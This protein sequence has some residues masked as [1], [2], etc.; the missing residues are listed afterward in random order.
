MQKNITTKIVAILLATLM[1]IGILPLDINAAG[2][3]NACPVE[4]PTNNYRPAEQYVPATKTI[5][6][7]GFRTLSTVRDEFKHEEI[8][9]DNDEPTTMSMP[10]I[11]QENGGYST[12]SVEAADWDIDNQADG[13]FWPLAQ[14]NNLRR[15][16]SIS[17]PYRAPDI[18]YVG[19]YKNADGDDVIRLQFRKYNGSQSR[20]WR[21]LILKFDKNIYEAI[22]WDNPKTCMYHGTGSSSGLWNVS[23]DNYTGETAKFIPVIKSYSGGSYTVE[24]DIFN[25]SNFATFMTTFTP[26]DFVLKKGE[27]AKL[28]N[29]EYLIQAR[30]MDSLYKDVY[31]NTSDAADVTTYSAYTMS[32]VLPFKG[33]YEIESNPDLSLTIGDT[34][35]AN[36]SPVKSAS[37]YVVYDEVN[38]YV[39]VFHKQVK[40]SLSDHIGLGS[41]NAALGFRQAVNKEFYDLLEPNKDGVVAIMTIADK[42]D[43]LYKS[44]SDNKQSPILNPKKTITFKKQA[45]ATDNQINIVGDVGFIQAAGS[46]WNVNQDFKDGIKTAI[47]NNNMNNIIING[48]DTMGNSGASTMVRYFVNKDKLNNLIKQ[49][50][51]KSYA[52]YSAV[53]RQDPIGT[54]VFKQKT[55]NKD[56][57]L[58]KG[59]EVIFDFNYNAN[60]GW[61]REFIIGTKPYSINFINSITKVDNN[62]FKW[63]IP[64]DITIPANTDITYKTV[65]N[66]SAKNPKMTVVGLGLTPIDMD[67]PVLENAPRVLRGS[68]TLAGGALVSTNYVVSVDE[69][70]TE[71]KKITG[72]SFYEVAEITISS[73]NA[74]EDKMDE[75]KISASNTKG[76]VTLK[77][78]DKKTGKKIEKNFESYKFDTGIPNPAGKAQINQYKEFVMPNLKKDMPIIVSNKDV[79]K[80][81]TDSRDVVEQVQAR[82]YFHYNNATRDEDE[83]VDARVMPLNSEFLY[84]TSGT[85]NPA[86]IPNGFLGYK[87]DSDEVVDNRRK[88][89][90]D[91]LSDHNG[92]PLEGEELKKRQMP[93][94]KG[95]DA[96]VKKEDMK[97]LGWSTKQGTTA[98]QFRNAKELTTLAEWKNATTIPFKFTE[99]SPI[100]THQHVY[101]VWGR[102]ID[103][104]L[105]GNKTST[106]NDVYTFNVSESDL[107]FDEGNKPFEKNGKKYAKVKMP[108]VFYTREIQGD[109]K[110]KEK[111]YFMNGYTDEEKQGNFTD[112]ASLNDTELLNK[113]E[114][115]KDRKTFVGW[116]S[117]VVQDNFK[118][119]TQNVFSDQKF[120]ETT[121]NRALDEIAYG[122]GQGLLPNGGNLL[123]EVDDNNQL[124]SNDDIDLYANY[125]PYF[126]VQIKKVTKNENGQE[127]KLNNANSTKKPGTNHPDAIATPTV[128]IGL[129]HR[130]AVTEVA[131]PTVAAA[132]N[133]YPISRDDYG[134]AALKLYSQYYGKYNPNPTDTFSWYVPGYDEYGQR[135]SYVGIEY[136][137]ISTGSTFDIKFEENVNSYYSFSRN[138]ASVGAYLLDRTSSTDPHAYPGQEGQAKVQTMTFNRT[139]YGKP[140]VD[141]FTGATQRTPIQASEVAIDIAN[142]DLVQQWQTFERKPYEVYGYNILMTN[143]KVSEYQPLFEEI[144][145]KS[146]SFVLTNPF[147]TDDLNADKE[148]ITGIQLEIKRDKDSEPVVYHLV[149]DKNVQKFSFI[150]ENEWRPSS[151][152]IDALKSKL[153]KASDSEKPAIQQQLSELEAKAK[154]SL[155]TNAFVGEA[156]KLEIIKDYV[157]DKQTNKTANVLKVTMPDSFGVFDATGNT[158][159]VYKSYVKAAY[160]FNATTFYKKSIEKTAGTKISAPLEFGVNNPRQL[161]SIL[162]A[163]TEQ[164]VENENVDIDENKDIVNENNPTHYVIEADVPKPLLEAPE[165]GKTTY[166]LIK[167]SDVEAAQQKAKEDLNI[168]PSE[169]NTEE[170]KAKIELAMTEALSSGELLGKALSS[171]KLKS[172]NDTIKFVGS[173]DK[174]VKEIEDPDNSGKMKTVAEDMYVISVEEDKLPSKSPIYTPDLESPKLEFEAKDDRW[175]FYIDLIAEEKID[176]E[177][178]G[179]VYIKVKDQPLEKYNSQDKLIKRVAA[180]ER[181]ENMKIDDILI[182]AYDKYNNKLVKK[183]EYKATVIAPIE[184]ENPIPTLDG[185]FAKSDIGNKITVRVLDKTGQKLLAKGE[186]TITADEMTFIELK[187]ADNPSEAYELK[188]DDLVEF[189]ARNSNGSY[190]NPLYMRPR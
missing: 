26:M 98:E 77:Y 76:S 73:P 72:D 125:R 21:R 95:Q 147:L 78:P 81:S 45:G 149:Y 37:S 34:V 14:T 142:T 74:T 162:D 67:T 189:V 120:N 87:N 102:G 63:T 141:T 62:K 114:S 97:F 91:I 168:S 116:T 134:K 171:Y 182:V 174:A 30:M 38:G 9:R 130:T 108:R 157:V 24:Q 126:R 65:N 15:V 11:P 188:E 144:E 12:R 152:E 139:H 117:K 69:L 32:T 54:L 93:I 48:A 96:E 177:I 153:R 128:Q 51:I 88:A 131:K 23:H 180:L 29:N 89:K 83:K 84:T 183:P 100:E 172:K 33:V 3:P 143:T 107:K 16:S 138:W 55:G 167:A 190:S 71:D 17:E 187:Q 164:D 112:V 27:L 122:R 52:F 61:E 137:V 146:N 156:P 1:V 121:F 66:T 75:Q 85:K 161:K 31:T 20:L 163:K 124:K 4:E 155:D 127:I 8:N 119:S 99:Y 184:A 181:V 80:Q 6:T 64:F 136:P 148:K 170:N 159:N 186:V 109:I 59:N 46:N 10:L 57:I 47:T 28:K 160:R 41:D 140:S 43:K 79:L 132:A 70:F 165:A 104:R 92:L 19:V 60:Q 166:Y 86:Y 2:I 178:F 18:K 123:L 58:K 105:H 53:I 113:V 158:V 115:Y 40:R 111:A 94:T 56:V 151:D 173:I 68:D 145:N 49:D 135:F 39:D 169:E 22:N 7:N 150:A 5:E 42:E 36:R 44:G 103:I 82:V 13:N 129:F 110:G 90:G 133:Y 35:N 175:R 50:G 118:L 25:T 154:K 106:D 176:G 101:A 185:V 179:E